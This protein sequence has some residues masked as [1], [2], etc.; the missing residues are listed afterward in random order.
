MKK[1]LALITILFT[2]IT[3][4]ACDY[5]E[6]ETNDTTSIES[7]EIDA[8]TLDESYYQGMVDLS[9]MS[10]IVNYDD[11]TSETVNV[12]ETMLSQ[13]DIDHL[14]VIGIHTILIEYQGYYTSMELTIVDP[15]LTTD[16]T[17]LNFYYLNDL[18]GALLEDES[19]IGMANIANFLKS[20]K[21]REDAETII[22][23]GGDHLQG[24]LLSNDSFGASTL[25]IFDMIGFDAVVLGNHEFDW[26]L[27]TV[28]S[29]Y[30]DEEEA[31]YQ[32]NHPMLAANVVYKDTDTIPEG[33]EPYTIVERDGLKIGIIGTIGYGLESSIA[34]LRVE[35]YEFLNPVPIV[36]ELATKLR[37]EDDVDLVVL[38]SHDDSS[39]VT[40]QVAAL[41][42]D[43]NIDAIFKG[44]SHTI[45]NEVVNDTPVL[46][47]R[48][49]GERVG[50]IQFVIEDGEIVD[51]TVRNLSQYADER[52]ETADSEVA[53][54]ISGLQD[55]LSEYFEPLMVTDRYISSRDL[56]EWIAE[57]MLD[58][59][60]ADFA[61]QNSGGTRNDI[62][63]GA[64]VSMSTLLQIF[65]F[66][67][68]VITATVSGYDV[69]NLQS[70]VYV[71]NGSN[72]VVGSDT[73]TIATNDYVFY[74]ENNNLDGSDD[75]TLAYNDMR[76]L[77]IQELLLQAEVYDYFD[78]DN[79]LLLPT[80]DHS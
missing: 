7:I 17:I 19:S 47:S 72:S 39:D 80:Q 79:P 15:P 28:T 57:L 69:Q 2:T 32:A 60:G 65:P 77:A 18:H 51:K 29:Y 31:T 45:I 41:E 26:G 49:N 74:H 8:D 4:I 62:A 67:N 33:L 58:M 23:S 52:L 12:S 59:T 25:E 27:D 70:N 3:L 11:D 61:F 14:N 64:E 1:L 22:L 16:G 56:S 9:T 6:P 63:E 20:E 71:S 35:D 37:T 40:N 46:M 36:S 13:S 66:D 68:Q 43:A 34:R 78:T 73:Y 53:N 54:Y 38:L 10:L 75:I 76:D 48:A 50:H 5:T 21:L 30:G 55:S 42:G 24:T 44:H